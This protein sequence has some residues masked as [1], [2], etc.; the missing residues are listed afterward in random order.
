MKEKI[1][2]WHLMGGSN[3]RRYIDEFILEYKKH[4]GKDYVVLMLES[5]LDKYSQDLKEGFEIAAS[6]SFFFEELVVLKAENRQH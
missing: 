1:Q 5:S 3:G 2:I 6:E 4:I